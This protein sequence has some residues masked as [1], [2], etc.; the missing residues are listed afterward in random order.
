MRRRYRRRRIVAAIVIM[1]IGGAGGAAL[2]LALDDGDS[3]PDGRPSAAVAQPPNTLRPPSMPRGGTAQAAP[4]GIS[5]SGPPAQIRFKKPP[6][7]ALIMDVDTGRVL[8]SGVW[9]GRRLRL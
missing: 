9:P 8:W 1:A 4:P 5:F 2:S 6:R 7:A 3:Q